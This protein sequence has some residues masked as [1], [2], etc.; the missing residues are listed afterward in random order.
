MIFERVSAVGL[1][2]SSDVLKFVK[3]FLSGYDTVVQCI[4]WSLLSPHA[5]L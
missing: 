4:D 3:Y 2:S 1:F 5:L